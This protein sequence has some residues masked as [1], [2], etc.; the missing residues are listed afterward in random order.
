MNA[1]VRNEASDIEPRRL[2]LPAAARERLA[3]QVGQG[4]S[5][6]EA[7]EASF[8]YGVPWPALAGLLEHFLLGFELEPQPLF[9]APLFETDVAGERLGFVHTRSRDPTAMPLLLLH[10]YLGSPAEFQH[11]LEPLASAGDGRIAFHVVCPLLAD[12]SHPRAAA[13]ACAELMQRLGY[14]RYAVHGSDLGANIALELGDLDR[15]HVA[16][17]HVTAIPAYPALDPDELGSLTPQEKS[18]LSRLTELA[19]ELRWAL[20]RSPVEDV[21]FALA[22]FEDAEVACADPR[23]RDT[24]LTSLT[25]AWSLADQDQRRALYRHRLDAAPTSPAPL[26]VQSFPL[27]AP[28]LRRFAERDHRVAE[29]N[30]HTQG[31]GMPALEQPELLLAS[32]RDFFTKL[33]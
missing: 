8:S 2:S 33:C 21:A 5:T 12:A 18:R 10:G 25:L 27:D 15:V 31:G 23:L 16:G 17:L 1:D 9:G 30:E 26:A 7:L 19:D 28:N 6:G 4:L 14:A 20:P 32:L 11:L 29:W 3:L 22:R 24:L 13:E